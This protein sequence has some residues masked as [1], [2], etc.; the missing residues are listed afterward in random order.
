[1]A[2]RRGFLLPLVIF[3]FF[4]FSPVNRGP[5]DSRFQERPSIEDAIAEE[6]RSLGVLQN[7]SY[8]DFWRRSTYGDLLIDDG[9]QLNLTGLWPDRGFEWAALPAVK[10]RAEEFLGNALGSAGIN[11]LGAGGRSTDLPPLYSNVTG[12]VHGPW[13]RSKLREKVAQPHLNLS[14]YAGQGPYGPFQ[15][16]TFER[17]IT[18]GT[19]D[20]SIRFHERTAHDLVLPD[21]ANVTGI[22]VEMTLR[23]DVGEN[24]A[25][26]QLYGVYNM[27][28]GQAILTTTS[29]KMAGI[30]MLPHCSL[31][32]STYESAKA[33]L[34]QSIS[35]ILKKRKD[36]DIESFNPWPSSGN[37]GPPMNTD[38]PLCELIVWLQQMPPRGLPATNTQQNIL[39]FLESELRS[40]TGAFLPPAPEL[41]FNMIAFSPDC[42]YVLE[43]KGE[44]DFVPQDGDHLVGPKIEA[45]F[46]NGRHHLVFFAL[47]IG[48]Q[49]ALLKRQMQEA[50]TPSTRSR[51]SFT[52]V[53]MLAL[54][55]GFATMTFL[56]VSLF[57]SNLWLDLMAAAFLAF[58]SVSFFGMRFMFDIWT[59]HAPERERAA[60]EE[61]EEERQ[62]RER[63]QV[64]LDRI[65]ADR[66]ERLRQLTERQEA[67]TAGGPPTD[68]EL[69]AAAAEPTSNE[70][71]TPAVVEPVVDVVPLPV[72]V[73]APGTEETQPA[74]DAVM[75]APSADQPATVS[76]AETPAAPERLPLPATARRPPEAFAT[77]VWMP[78]DQAGI[79]TQTADGLQVNM[80]VEPQTSTFGSLYMR[81]YL[82]LLAVLFISLNAAGWPTT[83]RRVYFTTLALLYLSFW[84][85]QII[86]NVQRNCRK[87]FRTEFVLGESALR[88][89]PFVYFFAYKHNV[90]FASQDLYS[91]ALLAI[92]VWVQIIVITSQE[93]IGPRWF[94]R[95]DWAPPAYD[96]HP[97]LRS[98][99]EGATLP[100]GLSDANSSSA[101]TSPLLEQRVSLSSPQTARRTSLATTKE[102]KEKGKRIYDCAICFQDLEVPVIEADG[103]GD[104]AG[105]A[106]SLAGGLLA[107]R[108]YM[109]TPCRHIF[110]SACLE[111]WMKYRL[112]CPICREGL[113]AL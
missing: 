48:S 22:S 19:G 80:E 14:S 108:N 11:A 102:H 77:P 32:E 29:D 68:A 113:P 18:G 23:E 65:H 101:P 35:R 82:V 17:N 7:S 87:A 76:A 44:P 109:V 56:L 55:D 3:A 71:A 81:F 93:I 96:Y 97:V 31:S 83:L 40:P 30:F 72:A 106:A 46:G 45:L 98:D 75:P 27:D 58:V 112:Q 64:A 74:S 85:P 42:G 26:L 6:E 103:S 66:N 51:I 63:L 104:N 39:G 1:M 33:Y 59:A 95:K 12:Y 53:A 67:R 110:H 5:I 91:L 13:V 28:I 86:R 50:S 24:D 111:G 57:I 16:N 2:D 60:R 70:Q 8:T 25:E 10:K 107:R 84:I 20:V 4:I 89:M 88:L 38:L 47:V 78:L 54:G 105:T 37:T 41:R 100:L 21:H 34:N 43:S 69:A 36:G 62:R 90:V 9:P 92:W 73:D 52:T 49:I 15:L 94:V 79:V 61:A 99:E